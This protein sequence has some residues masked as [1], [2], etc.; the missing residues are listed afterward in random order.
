MA[1][2][3]DLRLLLVAAAGLTLVP[4]LAA[5]PGTDRLAE[6]AAALDSGDGIS[7]EVAVDRAREAGLPR[8]Q[9]AAFAGEAELLLGDLSAARSWLEAGRFSRASAQRG[10]HALARLEVLEDN[11]RAAARA[12]DLALARG[13]ANA[14]LWVDIGRFRY[15]NGQHSLAVDA[16]EHAL[17]ID[18]AD[19]RALEF[20]GQLLRDAK[21][22][23]SAV[24]WFE[25]AIEQAPDDLGL[26]GEYAATLAEAGENR[27]MLRVARRMVELDP[28]HPR[29]YFLQAVL[30]ARAGQDDLAR[31]LLWRAGGAYDEVP[32]G[33]LLAGVLELRTGNAALAVR[34]FDTLARQQ[35]DNLRAT[36]LLGRALL[37]AGEPGEVIARFEAPAAR[38]DASP[39]LLTLVGR[40]HEQLGQRGDAGV[41][42]DRAAA[43]GMRRPGVLP[44]GAAG[45]LAI[46]RAGSELEDAG[47]AVPLLR[48][49]LAE[50]R[51]REAL[52]LSA[53]LGGHYPGSTD[54]DRLRGDVALL[55]GEP[56]AALA[57]YSRAA[58]IRSDLALVERMVAAHR[59]LGREP[60][61]RLL[62]AD[63][64]LRNPR[65]GRAAAMLGRMQ[66][67]QG[68]WRSAAALLRYAVRLGASDPQLLTDLAAAELAAGDAQRAQETSRRAHGLQRANGRVAAVLARALQSD[69]PQL[70]GILLA[71]SQALAAPP[72]LAG[73]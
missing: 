27:A 56:D 36:L 26:L 18:P 68:D 71:K 22:A 31:R 19:P 41:Y 12:F 46:W 7:A 45:D 6:A 47:A 17:S 53:L 72:Q 32:A 40:A 73:R 4:P 5:A 24:Q 28:R 59:Q 39:Y 63:H 60:A 30:A 8:E 62:L 43:A 48:Q 23:R 52:A 15:A 2:R 29:A 3:P 21:G 61:V 49:M 25:R 13:P 65:D 9:V 42:L 1:C 50:G 54:V 64:V 20:R 35:P 11:T 57:L 66:A 58:A 37:A 67:S 10:F 38:P 34:R 55:A 69:E 44:I 33:Q 16:A 51:A 14:R 70:A